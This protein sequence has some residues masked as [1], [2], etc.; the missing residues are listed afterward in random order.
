MILSRRELLRISLKAGAGAAVLTG[1]PGPLLAQLGLQADPVQ[2][3]QDALVK[4]LALRAVAAATDA[5]ASYADVR[6]THTRQRDV[7]TRE[8]GNAEDVVV[9]VRSLVD[10]YWGFAGSRLWTP[11]EMARLGRESVAL[12]RALGIGP[13]R[14]VDLAGAPVPVDEHWAMPVELDPFEDVAPGEVGDLLRGITYFVGAHRGFA[15]WGS[16]KATFVVQEKAFASSEGAYCTQRLYRSSGSIEVKLSKNGRELVRALDTLTPAG[17]GWEHFKRQPLRENLGRL[18]DEMDE[19]IMMS[20][21]PVDVGRY[22]VVCD[23]RTIVRLAGVTLGTAT[24][25]DRA[26]G[27]EANASGTSYL[28]TPREMV[29]RYE[30]GSPLLTLTANRSEGG[31]AATVAWDDE[32]VRPDDFALVRNGVL[33]DFQTTR[34]SAAWLADAGTP[35]GEIRSHGCAAAPTAVSA[36]LTHTPNLTVAPGSEPLDFEGLVAGIEEG[37]AV[38][39]MAV[40]MDFQGLNGMGQGRVYEVKD[41]KRVA[42]VAGAGFLFRAPELWK[43]LIAVGGEDSMRRYGVESS[44]GEPSQTTYH[45]V[46]APPAVIEAFT[47][48]DPKRKA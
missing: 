6:L 23:A 27:Y 11:D 41:G 8:V 40:E 30:A 9:G 19:D 2:S 34:E 18:M 26:F 43:Q 20:V 33:E 42:I 15:V 45:S 17:L 29:G 4:E 35:P 36:P 32:G 10:G 28:N 31:G 39:D 22:D 44:K 7:T 12:A 1:I 13:A 24:Q 46:S 5:G 16:P 3:I 47:V 14:E 21:K 48:I 38:K 37:L 25:L